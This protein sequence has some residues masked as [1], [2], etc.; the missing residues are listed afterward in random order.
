VI[1]GRLLDGVL[2]AIEV[3]EEPDQGSD[4]A[5]LVAE[6]VL[7]QAWRSSTGRISIAPP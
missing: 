6:D 5:P 2:G 7:D 4:N 1:P 3:A